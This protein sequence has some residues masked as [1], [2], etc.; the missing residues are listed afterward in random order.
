MT[1]NEMRV[2]PIAHEMIESFCNEHGYTFEFE[3]DTWD[4]EAVAQI[5]IDG[6]PVENVGEQDD[7]LCLLHSNGYITMT[8]FNLDGVTDEFRTRINNL[9][10]AMDE[11]LKKE[12]L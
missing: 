6:L 7:F 9:F 8:E 12:G 1:N 2:F 11:R 3:R 4:G 5:E 10:D